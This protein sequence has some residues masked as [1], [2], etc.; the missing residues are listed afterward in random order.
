M[1]QA[2]PPRAREELYD[3]SVDPDELTDV[4]RE[5]GY[6]DLRRRLSV[7]LDAHL[8]ASDDPLVTGEMPEPAPPRRRVAVPASNS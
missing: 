6:G 1:T 8:V 3:L 2:F 4:S 7:L 5:P